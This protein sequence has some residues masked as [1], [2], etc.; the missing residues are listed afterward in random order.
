MTYCGHCAKEIEH[1]DNEPDWEYDGDSGDIV[2]MGIRK[3]YNHIHSG[4]HQCDSRRTGAIPKEDLICI[5][6]KK[7]MKAWS[8]MRAKVVEEEKYDKL[9]EKKARK[10]LMNDQ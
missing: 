8:E 6:D 9:Y 4:K 7:Q 10:L 2:D 3:I 5:T 1:V